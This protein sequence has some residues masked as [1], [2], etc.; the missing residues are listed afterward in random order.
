KTD[1]DGRRVE[2]L[3]F[4]A[5]GT[6]GIGLSL[7]A[8]ELKR[9]QYSKVFV[10][11][12]DFR[13]VDQLLSENDNTDNTDNTLSPARERLVK[14]PCDITCLGEMERTLSSIGDNSIHD[15][16]STQ[17]RHEDHRRR[18][19]ERRRQQ[20]DHRQQHSGMSES[21]SRP[22]PSSGIND[23]DLD[24]SNMEWNLGRAHKV[25]G[26]LGRNATSREIKMAYRLESRRWHPD[27]HVGKSSFKEAESRMQTINA[28]YEYL[29]ELSRT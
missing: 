21:P 4:I 26:N 18:Q 7:L 23:P 19:E 15:F 27:H 13:K 12:R 3:V 14:V 22:R 24:P 17:Q 1:N 2:D 5:G 28:A 16:V 10:L 9:A 20:Q 8:L 11:G 6:D 29:R 25:L